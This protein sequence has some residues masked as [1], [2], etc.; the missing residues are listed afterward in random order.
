MIEADLTHYGFRI[1]SV[2]QVSEEFSNGQIQTTLTL[3]SNQSA[4]Q[5]LPELLASDM[6]VMNAVR[7]SYDPAVKEAYE[8][9]LTVMA[10]TKDRGIPDYPSD[11]VEEK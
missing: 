2:Q 1:L 11:E 7:S 5:I 9:L 3:A 6:T 10:L 4:M 8:Q